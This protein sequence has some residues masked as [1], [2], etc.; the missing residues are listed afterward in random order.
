MLV[1]ID[2][3]ISKPALLQPRRRLCGMQHA[4]SQC[5]QAATAPCEQQQTA[6]TACKLQKPCG[7]SISEVVQ[8]R[9]CAFCGNDGAACQAPWYRD[10]ANN[11]CRVQRATAVATHT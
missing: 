4:T 2:S 5:L 11:C 7:Q 10:S 6:D 8:L 3:F 9:C 1:L